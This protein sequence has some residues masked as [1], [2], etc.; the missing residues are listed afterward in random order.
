MRERKMRFYSDNLRN[1][2]ELSQSP[3]RY[4]NY[5][6]RLS[7]NNEEAMY[8][9]ICCKK[10]SPSMISFPAELPQSLAKKKI[11]IYVTF[12]AGQ[13]LVQCFFKKKKQKRAFN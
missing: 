9:R 12:G 10:K 8:D 4:T 13:Y 2:F 7:G 5:N 11:A 1:I 6:I 3:S